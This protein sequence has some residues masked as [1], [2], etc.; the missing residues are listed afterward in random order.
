M[1]DAPVGPWWKLRNT[2]Q[3]VEHRAVAVLCLVFATGYVASWLT[4][5][6]RWD[7]VLLGSVWIVAAV[8]HLWRSR[9]RFS[10]R[11]L[12]IVLTIAAVGLGAISLLVSGW[13]N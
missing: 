5:R 13:N 11:A 2:P 9:I 12:F 3:H 4:D 7:L 8:V 10:L 1:H 6:S